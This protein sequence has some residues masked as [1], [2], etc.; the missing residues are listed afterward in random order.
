MVTVGVGDGLTVVVGQGVADI[1]G[2]GDTLVDPPADG[3]VALTDG[4]GGGVD[5]DVGRSVAEGVG[6]GDETTSLRC[7]LSAMAPMMTTTT[8]KRMT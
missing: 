1:R 4:V 6:V 7:W 5:D 3:G 2:V 8:T